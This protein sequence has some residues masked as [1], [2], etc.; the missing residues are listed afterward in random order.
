MHFL[1]SFSLGRIRGIPIRA[2]WSAPLGLLILIVVLWLEPSGRTFA[3]T[4]LQRLLE[5]FVIAAIPAAVLMHELA[6]ALAAGIWGIRT[7][8]IYLHIFG[9]L[10][11]ATDPAARALTHPKK[12]AIL[13]AGPASNFICCAIAL[14]LAHFSAPVSSANCSN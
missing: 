11:L 13:S 6:H 10:A 14:G 5:L 12:M 7:Q 9:G 1:A 8:G 3:V 2:H 4:L